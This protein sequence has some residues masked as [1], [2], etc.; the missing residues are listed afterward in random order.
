MEFNEILSTEYSEKFD[1][2]R[3]N[4]MVVSYYKYG[5][6]KDNYKTFKTIDAIKS[7]EIRLEKYKETGNTEFLADIANFAM[8]EYMY[9]QHPD[10]HYNSTDNGA[11]EIEGFGI[12][13]IKD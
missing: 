2:I 9:P 10:A 4:M 13:E 3:K 11:C 7:L 6:I 5:A 1:E 8:I 12:N